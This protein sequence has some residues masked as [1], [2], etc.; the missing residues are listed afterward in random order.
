MGL[1]ADGS[2]NCPDLGSIRPC[3]PKALPAAEACRFSDIDRRMPTTS[4]RYS[5]P[6]FIGR[7]TQAH[8][9]EELMLISVY[10]LDH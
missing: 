8:P 4:S 5:G 9:L 2:Y 7:G 1:N 3:L 6:A 10:A